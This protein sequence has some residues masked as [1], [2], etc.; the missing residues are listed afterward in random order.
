MN[1]D[2]LKT[3]WAA[4]E[5]TGSPVPPERIWQAARGELPADETRALLNQLSADP[6]LAQEWRLALA[7]DGIT[8]ATV[9]ELSPLTGLAEG[10]AQ[11]AQAALDWVFGGQAGFG[12]AW[13]TAS[14]LGAP[15][16]RPGD[17][18]QVRIDDVDDAQDRR[19][20]VLRR[21]ERCWEVVF[22]STPDEDLRLGELQ[23]QSDGTRLLDLLAAE[24]AGRQEWAVV[25]PKADR[26]VDFDDSVSGR[27]ASLASDV[28]LGG[29]PWAAVEVEVT[30]IG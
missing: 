7:L 12:L 5:G 25:L 14:V 23:P 22:P 8:L 11:A 20:V 13:Q 2:D 1:D 26:P 6:Q 21:Q 24:P 30:P 27:W 15:K 3:L 17:R 9:P 18:F 4:R 10:A 29:V 28:E 19:V 16:V